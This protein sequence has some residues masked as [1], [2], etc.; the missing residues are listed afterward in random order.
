LAKVYITTKLEGSVT[1]IY[2]ND[3][4]ILKLATP[5]QGPQPLPGLWKQMSNF[6]DTRY[7]Q[8][9]QLVQKTYKDI[10]NYT[11]E[12]VEYQ[13]VAGINFLFYYNGPN[14]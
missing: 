12:R 4:S 1:E 7:I 3:A 8:C 5:I 6:N 11:L 10:D 13:V 2:K 9:L 14:S